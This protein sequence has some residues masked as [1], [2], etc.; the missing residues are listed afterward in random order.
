MNLKVFVY[1]NMYFPFIVTMRDFMQT[2]LDPI[3]WT[4]LQ[5]VRGTFK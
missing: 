3:S 1:P 2:L 5:I 4:R